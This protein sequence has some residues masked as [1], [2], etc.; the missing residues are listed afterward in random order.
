MTRQSGCGNGGWI[1][2]CEKRVFES[3]SYLG[4]RMGCVFVDWKS[5]RETICQNLDAQHGV[6]SQGSV[7]SIRVI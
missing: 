5:L 1:C 2:L 3:N 6:K 4:C 7:M